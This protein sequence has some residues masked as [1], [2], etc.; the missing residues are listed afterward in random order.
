MGDTKQQGF[1]RTDEGLTPMQARFVDA[2]IQDFNG[3]AAA[4]AAGSKGKDPEKAAYGFLRNP[5]V[6]AAINRRLTKVSEKV[7]VDVQWVI[8]KLVEVVYRSLQGTPKVRRDGTPVVNPDTG[9]TVMDWQPAAANKALELLGRHLGMFI[10]RQE[11]AVVYRSM[12]DQAIADLEAQLTEP[13]V[14]DVV[15]ANNS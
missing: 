10:D 8:S 15:A 7:D 6:S 9:A 2:Y 12:V 3:A 11:V 1:V 13:R 14:V 5:K 4:R